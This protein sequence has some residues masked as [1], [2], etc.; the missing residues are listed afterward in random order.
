MTA[1]E[2]PSHSSRFWIFWVGFR[3][4]KSKKNLRFLN[5]ITWLSIL[6]IAAGVASMI[7]VLSVMDGFEAQLKKK[8]MN[9]DLHLLIQPTMSVPGFERGYVPL[10]SFEQSALAGLLSSRPGVQSLT[11]VVSTEVILKLARKVSGVVLKGVSAERLQRLKPQLIESAEAPMLTKRKGGQ[12]IKIPGLFVGQELAFE[13]GLLPGDEVNAI[14]PTETDGPAG[15]IPRVKPFVIEGIYRS[16]IPEQEL[17]TVFASQSS[18]WSFLRQAQ[19]ANQWEVALSHFDEAPALS[20]FLRPKAAPFRVQDWTELNA[21]LFSSLKLERISMFVILAFIVVVA[22]FNMVT[23]LTLM[24]TE[25]RREISIL[26][27]M[28]ASRAEISGVFLAEGL[29]VGLAGMAAGL[30]GGY[31]LCIFLSRYELIRLP[32]IYYDR[33]LPVAFEPLYY[34][35]IATSAMLI[36][37]IACYYPSKRAS[38]LDLI[39]GLKAG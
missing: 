34:A 38:Q 10:A 1:A 29:M 9:F 18:V 26:R 12:S 3:Y 25:K 17:H 23:T 11:P 2:R 24:V 35:L 21:H 39:E 19:V 5:L 14:S 30:S 8:L 36:V 4:L 6:G 15:G 31:V 7:V 28:G 16:G 27:A 32:E 20:E 13:M 37:L 22:S 33:T